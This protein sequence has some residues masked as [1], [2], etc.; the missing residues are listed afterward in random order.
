[1]KRISKLFFALAVLLSAAAIAG[2]QDMPPQGPPPGGG[3]GGMRQFQFPQFKDLDKNKDGKLS[4]DEM[5][6]QMPPQAFDRLDA[7]HDG[8][9][10]EAEWNAIRSRMGGGPRVGE[11]M[12]KFLDADKDGKVTRDEFAK[13]VA[14]FDLLDA[15]HDGALSQEE[16]NNF[17]RAMNEAQ[18][19]AQNQATG[20]VDVN[21]LFAN[22]DKNKDG[23]LT[24]DEI[25]NERLF[26]RLDLNKDGVVTRDEAETALKQLAEERAKAKKPTQ[27]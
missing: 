15:N 11:G 25:T 7:N 6:S 2:A 19:Q 4:R 23:K 22:N 17:F 21:N 9:I 3:G 12:A 8:F 1:M 20:G 10:D 16:M 18:T 13:I 14:L 26:K 5:P 27:P 24:P